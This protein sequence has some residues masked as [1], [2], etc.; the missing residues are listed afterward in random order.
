MLILWR[1]RRG[2]EE[3][4][5]TRQVTDE[6]D[7]YDWLEHECDKAWGPGWLSIRDP[8]GRRTPITNADDMRAAF[9]LMRQEHVFVA[10]W[11]PRGAPGGSKHPL[12]YLI[13]HIELAV[14]LL[15]CCVWSRYGVIPAMRC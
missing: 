1:V 12:H 14:F 2:K 11:H 10:R 6:K 15:G 7:D 5:F 9:A 13:P 3:R 4:D 8:S